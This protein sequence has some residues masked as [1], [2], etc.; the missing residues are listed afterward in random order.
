MIIVVFG[1]SAFYFWETSKEA[2]FERLDKPDAD[3]PQDR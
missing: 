3:S 2:R 1:G